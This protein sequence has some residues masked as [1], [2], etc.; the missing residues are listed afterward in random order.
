VIDYTRCRDHRDRAP[1]IG[2]REI[3]QMSMSVY[4]SLLLHYMTSI[5]NG[6]A[7]NSPRCGSDHVC[8]SS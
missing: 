6:I 7:S 5:E 8:L 4:A 1:A 3:D 2:N